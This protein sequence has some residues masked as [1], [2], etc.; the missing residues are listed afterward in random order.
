MALPDSGLDLSLV[1]AV[2]APGRKKI[3]SRAAMRRTVQTSPFFPAWV[4]QVPRDIEQMKAAIAAAD[5]TAVGELAEAN[6]MR[7][8]ATMLGALPPVRYWN[9]D[10]VAALDLV[11]TLRDEGTECYAT[12]D[13]GPN[14][15]VL[16]RSGD[17]EA[18]AERFRAEFADI[19]VLVSGSGPG[20]Y[21]V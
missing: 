10:S 4:E 20:A 15:K 1:V 2:L 17:A 5:F 18:I 21:L 6:A 3:D 14:V 8:H 11:A 9:P 13:A 7:M 19:D 12:M 16:C